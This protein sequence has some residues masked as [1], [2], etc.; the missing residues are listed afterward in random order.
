MQNISKKIID[1]TECLY[2]EYFKEIGFYAEL[3]YILLRCVFELTS[4]YIVV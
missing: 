3:K 1:F 4:T 2:V